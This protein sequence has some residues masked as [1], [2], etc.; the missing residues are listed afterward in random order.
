[1]AALADAELNEIERE[2]LTRYVDA[3]RDVYGD[4]LHGIWLFGSRARGERPHDESDLDLL[5]VTRVES[6]D[7]PLL[8]L[9]DDISVALGRPWVL[10][11]A[12]QRPLAWIE[13]RR[14]IRSFFL[15]EVDRDKIV[16]FGEP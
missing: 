12:R 14:A 9:Q 2:F 8:R 6:T 5:V 15:Q 7:D 11:D 4:E 3:L 13:D 10:I 16:L 1:M